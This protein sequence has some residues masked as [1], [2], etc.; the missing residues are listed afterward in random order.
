MKQI[1]NSIL[2]SDLY[3]F[4]QQWFVISHFSEVES[5]YKF[6]NRDLSKKF[7]KEAVEEIKR[8][9]NLMSN[10]KLSDPEYDWMKYNLSFLPVAYR[11]YLAAYRFNTSGIIYNLDNEGNLDISLKGKWRDYILWEVPM[12]A[13]IS[14]VY[15]VYM[16]TDW[17]MNGQDLQAARKAMTLT[18]AG[19]HFADF[20]TRRRRNF[21]TQDIVV[22]EM[23][24]YSGF[25]GTSNPY[26]AMK[27]G[28]KALGTCAHESIA[29]MA[30][31]VSL[32]H[33]NAVFMDKWSEVYEGALG[34]M[35]PDTF[36][37][38]SCIRD[39]DLRRS[40]LWDGQRHDSGDP[41]QFID[42]WKKHYNSFNID[43]KSKTL[44]F[45]NN[46]NVLSAIDINEY[47]RGVFKC[48]FGIGTFFTSDFTKASS[49][50]EISSPMNM[51]IKLVNVNGI[52]VVKLSDDI[53]KS[54]GDKTM[55]D[56]MAYI[57]FNNYK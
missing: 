2:D 42:K 38:D 23:K 51:V 32:N 22:R 53:G 10:L 20:G 7:S 40:K 52:P 9:A 49:P 44:I 28:V 29:A 5:T 27:H 15:F 54:I 55:I 36:G 25:T 37:T 13:I 43:T 14:E 17:N 1:I 33:P 18:N 47:C 16:D 11:Q 48:S 12:M 50:L 45:S 56:I 19:C 26:L 31:L 21:E 41:Y 8:Q 57:H 39:M 46:L 6:N 34:T 35:L 4:T 24:K 3:K 30:A